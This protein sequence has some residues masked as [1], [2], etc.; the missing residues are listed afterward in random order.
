MGL[1]KKDL[2]V[3]RIEKDDSCLYL[4]DYCPIKKDGN[5]CYPP[6]ARMLCEMHIPN[7]FPELTFDDEPIKVNVV[8]SDKETGL[9]IAASD[10]YFLNEIFIYNTKPIYKERIENSGYVYKRFNNSDSDEYEPWQIHVDVD[11]NLKSYEKPRFA[12]L[13]K[14]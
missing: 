3:T 4:S 8:E 12:T 11:T 7:I 9:W 5:W 1:P 6:G 10:G 14:V 13:K 2:Y